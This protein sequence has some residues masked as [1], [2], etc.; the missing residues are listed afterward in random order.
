MRIALASPYDFATHGGVNQHIEHLRAEFQRLGHE[1]DLIAPIAGAAEH[2]VDEP[3]FHGFGGIVPLPVNGSVARISFSPYLR[4]RIKDLMAREHFDVVH[5]HEPLMPALP[6][7]V[8]RYSRS[9]NVGTFHAYSETGRGYFYWR[10]VLA[11]FHEKLDGLIAV[12]EPAREYATHFFPGEYRIIPNGV[13]TSAFTKPAQPFPELMDGRSNLLF[14]GRFEEERKGFRYLIRALPWVRQ[15]Y[16]DVRLVVV[17]AGDPS[18]YRDRIRRLGIGESVVWA[19]R[20]SDEE[21]GRYMASCQ[22]FV[23]PSTG[24]ESQGVVLLE[25]MAAGLPVVAGDI[26]GYASVLTSGREGLLVPPE[27]EHALAVA[28]VRLLADP[29]LR[30]RMAS[31]GVRKAT[32]HSWP[33]VAARLLEFY[34]EIRERKAFMQRREERRSH[35]RVVLKRAGRRA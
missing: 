2:D 7:M 25:A 31:C 6:L 23:A 24:G 8:L 13:D 27:S 15:V 10:P 12:S 1:V 29:G 14:L 11:R 19:G 16:P 21:R 4:G 18:R 22:L 33:K 3:G 17:G 32:E 20:V 28:I 34:T 5:C 35:L 30:A 26:P 9:V